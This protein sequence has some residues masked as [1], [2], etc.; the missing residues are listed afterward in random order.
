MNISTTNRH[1]AG[2]L[3]TPSRPR[4]VS[5]LLVKV[6]KCGTFPLDLLRYDR[7]HPAQERDANQ[8]RESLMP[9]VEG[10]Q[11]ILVERF[12]VDPD[13]AWSYA[14]WLSHSG[15]EV[16]SVAPDFKYRRD[17]KTL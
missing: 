11:E 13:P 2:K 12:H 15:I 9:Y 5:Y 4:Y 10:E 7:C 1:N 14:N 17:D 8:L 6:A 3:D 16:E